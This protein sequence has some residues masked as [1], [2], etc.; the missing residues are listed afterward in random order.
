MR[1]V[2]FVLFCGLVLG[3]VLTSSSAG[4]QDGLRRSTKKKK[5]T[6]FLGE[7][8]A[9]AVFGTGF[10]EEGL[11]FGLRA[12]FGAGG[13]FK[14]FPPRFYAVLAVRYS[15]LSSTHESGTL[16][17]ELRRDLVDISL[18]LRVL[19]PIYRFRFLLEGGL[20][21]SMLFSSAQLNARQDFDTSEHR[22]TGYVATGFQ[23]RLHRNLSLGLL[24]EWALPTS[25][26]S[27]D[28]VADVS[29]IKDSGAMLGWT[30][31]SLTAVG[32]F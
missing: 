8:N 26:N 15:M 21:D 22:F 2:A 14:G 29:G 31:V 19:V 16:V 25:R 4:A 24:C 3:L 9:G 28:F 23:Y 18:G 11:G 12:T 10:S 27:V 1:R 17:S 13:A 20:G 6:H 30:S 7:L 32:H 5:G